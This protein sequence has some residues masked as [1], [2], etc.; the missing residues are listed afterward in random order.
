LLAVGFF[1]RFTNDPSYLQEAGKIL[2]YQ[3]L[4]PEERAMIDAETKARDTAQAILSHARNEGRDE[5]RITIASQ[6]IRENESIGR[7]SKYTGLPGDAIK[8]MI[9]A[10]QL[11]D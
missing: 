2:S 3:N 8:Q 11:I 6:M 5:V 1:P 10:T 4:H 9:A 7:I